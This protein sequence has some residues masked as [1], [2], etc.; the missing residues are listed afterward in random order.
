MRA[1]VVS[2]HDLDTP[3]AALSLSDL[4]KRSIEPLDSAKVTSLFTSV[5]DAN[6]IHGNFALFFQF[7]NFTLRY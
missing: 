4:A 3:V 7:L 1:C 6:E 5:A 2:V